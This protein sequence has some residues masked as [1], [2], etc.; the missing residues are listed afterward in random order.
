M[1]T[2]D[3]LN[4]LAALLLKWWTMPVFRYGVE[5]GKAYAELFPAFNAEK[6]IDERVRKID[7][8]RKNLVSA[9]S[10][11]DELKEEAALNMRKAH[12]LQER[13]ATLSSEKA[14][15]DTELNEVRKIMDSDVNAFQRVA[16][17]PSQKQIAKERLVGF[18]L[19][20]LASL[21]ATLG[22]E[23]WPTFVAWF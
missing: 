2:K 15:V 21:I 9:L 22:W 4:K 17:V 13:V 8:A 18:G 11:I 5:N 20:I 16:G 19:G 14:A 7:E 12:E 23:K 3:K 6:S 1:S 10:A